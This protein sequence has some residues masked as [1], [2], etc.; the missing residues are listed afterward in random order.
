MLQRNIK[1]GSL[2]VG[3]RIALCQ[4]VKKKKTAELGKRKEVI[5]KDEA[6]V[7]EV[8]LRL[9]E[10]HVEKDV[11]RTHIHP[12][13]TAASAVVLVVG[14]I[15]VARVTVAAKMKERCE[16]DVDLDKNLEMYF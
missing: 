12:P 2:Q 10:T 8:G 11:A 9:T 15:A 16:S 13:T 1:T 14:L 5:E 7:E 3:P 6:T 4:E